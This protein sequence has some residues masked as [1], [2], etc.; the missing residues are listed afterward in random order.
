[1]VLTGRTVTSG[2]GNIIPLADLYQ[3]K[4]DI[5]LYNDTTL[6]DAYRKIDNSSG[7]QS[8]WYVYHDVLDAPGTDA[9]AWETANASAL[10]AYIAECNLSVLTVSEFYALNQEYAS[11]I[12]AQFTPAGPVTLWWPNGQAFTDTSTGSPTGWDWQFN[13]VLGNATWL[14]FSPVQNPTF[15]AGQGNYSIRLNASTASASNISTQLTFVNVSMPVFAAAFSANITNGTYPLP[16]SFTDES[17]G[18]PTEWLWDFG[19][20][21]NS[22]DQNPTHI[23]GGC[24]QSFTI[25]LTATNSTLSISDYE[26]KPGYI[27]TANCTPWCGSIQDL[28]FQN[29]TYYDPHGYQELSNVPSGETET[30]I[31]TS[32]IDTDGNVLLSAFVTPPGLPDVNSILAGLQTYYI[33]ASVDN[34]AGTTTINATAF[35][36]YPNGSE[37]YLYS[38][39]TPDI[40]DL[41]I[42]EYTMPYVSSSDIILGRPDDRIAMK[43]YGKTTSVSAV[44]LTFAYQG[45]TNIS[46]VVSGYFYCNPIV[47]TVTTTIPNLPYRKDPDAQLPWWVYGTGIV[48]LWVILGIMWRRR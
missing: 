44:N 41:W 14:S 15:H 9:Y 46:H 42:S 16:V 33:Y 20:G 25:N 43:F 39:S 19:D 45:E 26:E 6:E 11:P 29:K 35:H 23:F 34:T 40:N 8:L 48:A 5:E 21:G 22:T 24:N 4:K 36:V 37:E 2:G 10:T 13:D 28:Y 31:A 30:D 3:I 32:L 12:V 18:G 47:P 1:M 7:N 38:K 27:R 17:T